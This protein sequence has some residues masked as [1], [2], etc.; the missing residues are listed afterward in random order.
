M[1][2]SK[3]AHCT[4]V[5]PTLRINTADLIAICHVSPHLCLHSAQ[6]RLIFAG[7]KQRLL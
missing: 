5:K 1:A 7:E 4:A 2:V 3:S 6:A